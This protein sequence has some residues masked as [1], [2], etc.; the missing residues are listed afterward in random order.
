MVHLF[1]LSF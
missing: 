1:M